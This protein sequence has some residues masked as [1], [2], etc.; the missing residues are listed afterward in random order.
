VLYNINMGITERFFRRLQRKSSDPAREQEINGLVNFLET[1]ELA[2]KARI[3]GEV[4]FVESF[5]SGNLNGGGLGADSE[6][7]PS[8]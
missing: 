7:T 5:N 6:Q 1:G 3:N 2:E 4:Y 8:D